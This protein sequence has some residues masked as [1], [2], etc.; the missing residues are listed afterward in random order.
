MAS[1]QKHPTSARVRH[2]VKLL[3]LLI[4]I[5]LPFLLV[6]LL[7]IFRN[8]GESQLHSVVQL[9]VYNDDKENLES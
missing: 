4:I 8:E 2:K 3:L 6:L 5:L 1:T 7:F 9:C